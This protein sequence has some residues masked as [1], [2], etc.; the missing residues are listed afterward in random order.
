MLPVIGPSGPTPR[1]LHAFGCCGHGFH[2]G[3]GVGAVLTELILDGATP[4]PINAFAI[5]R[6]RGAAVPAG[7]KL[8]AEF[9]PAILS[10]SA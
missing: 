3:P 10:A 1:L 7:S 9:D 2:I 5:T 4:T 8:A 6:F